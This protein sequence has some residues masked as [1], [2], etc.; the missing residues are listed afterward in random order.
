M[1]AVAGLADFLR[2]V[3]VTEKAGREFLIG[4][5]QALIGDL[6]NAAT[7][8]ACGATSVGFQTGARNCA[9]VGRGR[10]RQEQDCARNCGA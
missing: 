5:R 9:R 2:F 4:A 1:A 7:Y 3:R 6:L 8:R 10:D